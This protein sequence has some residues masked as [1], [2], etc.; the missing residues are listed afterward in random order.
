MC[1]IAGFSGKFSQQLLSEMCRSINHRGPDDAGVFFEPAQ[2]IGFAHTRLAIIDLSKHGHQP[3]FSEDKKVSIVFNGEIYNFCQLRESLVGKGYQFTGNSDTEVLLNLYLEYGRDLLPMLNGIFSFAIWDST[4]RSVFLARDQ[5]G[6]KP[7]YYTSTPKGYLFSS[8]L[9]SLLQ[10]PSVSRELDINGIKNYLTFLW[11][12]GETT[13]LANVH[14]LPPGHAQVV[15]DGKI[16]SQWCYYELK[17]GRSVKKASSE[18]DVIEGLD[19]QL[20]DA[21]KSQ[22]VADVPV[23]AFLSGGLDSS[24][25]VA[26]AKNVNPD[27]D[28][29]T[30]SIRF[31][32]EGLKA[33]GLAAD[34]PYAKRVAKHLNVK[35]NVVDVDSSIIDDL[36]KMIY[37][38]DEPQADPAPL[39]V[40]RISQLA[41]QNGSKVLLSG[42]GG[43]DLFTGYRRHYALGIEGYWSWLPSALR[44][45]LA[46]GA[47]ALPVKG[48]FSRRLSKLFSYSDLDALDRVK[49]YFFWLEPDRV[50]ALFSDQ[51][52]AQA[53]QISSFD[54]F[55]EN[56]NQADCDEL[57]SMLFW[58]M[59]HFLADHNLNYTDKM[60]M[61][62]GVEIRVPLID[63]NLVEYAASIDNQFKQKGR[64]GKWI[65]K[66]TMEPYLPKEVIYRPKTGFG[67][68][69]RY[70]LKSELKPMVNELLS[71]SSIVSRGVFN[72][73]EVKRLIEQ[74]RK[75]EKDFSYPIFALLS[76]EIWFRTFIDQ[77]TPKIITL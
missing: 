76:L 5:F 28:L 63:P 56:P 7:F 49:S 65:F 73:K 75:G 58:E 68:P 19:K 52:Q 20:K 50:N 72:P 30:Y 42:A 47:K 12:P 53:K 4:N 33:E 74:D 34:L 23:G 8:E 10:E 16:E 3:M 41:R 1:G 44:K 51:Y 14:K 39:N 13:M 61:A 6:V 77:A 69:L 43:D 70:W 21:V 11:S 48:A 9:K 31:K 40:A 60:G 71:E 35:L 17:Y 25:L 26:L 32:G 22:L 15:V 36:P 57:D 54:A 46:S 67:A 2:S 45:G 64:Q 38:L 66:R 55:V 59:K 24:A 62:E 27:L 29:Q 18:A 37:H